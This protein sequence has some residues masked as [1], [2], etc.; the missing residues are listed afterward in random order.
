VQLDRDKLIKRLMATF[1]EELQE[2][3]RIFNAEL[4]ALEQ[5]Q[6]GAST[7]ESIK[8]LFR[9]AH[10]L[11]GAARS[12]QAQ[13]LEGVCHQLE[14]LLAT[15][16]DGERALDAGV[17]KQLFAGVDAWQAA[18]KELRSSAPAARPAP[19]PFSPP[20]T[21]TPVE[22]LNA[23]AGAV[24]PVAAAAS[25]ISSPHSPKTP[26]PAPSLV[27]ATEPLTA[28]PSSDDPHSPSPAS[29]VVRV[30]GGRL[31]ALLSQ[32]GELMV[33]R[34]R[35]DARQAD[36]GLLQDSVAHFRNE[37]QSAR[38]AFIKTPGSRRARAAGTASD[39]AGDG[40]GGMGGMEGLD[41]A[42]DGVP[43]KLV[44]FLKHS[45]EHLAR[46]EKDLERLS[47]GLSED[48]RALDRAATPLEAQIHQARL[49]PFI[50]ACEGLFRS[51]RDLAASQ[52][53][54]IELAIAGGDTELDRSIIDGLR[55][56]LLHLIRNAAWHGIEAPDER[57][58]RHKPRRGTISIGAALH[59][60][61][62]RLSVADDGRGLDLDAVRAQLRKRDLPIPSDEGELARL[63]FQPGFSTASEVTA[64]SG[65]GVGLDV[66][67]AHIEA[68]RG[69]V[70][71]AF[72]PGKGTCF[73]ITLPLTLTTVRVL[74]VDAAGETF[75]FPTTSVRTLVRAGPSS[76]GSVEG[77]DMLLLGEAPIPIVSLGETLGLARAAT[78]LRANDKVPMVIVSVDEQRVALAVDEL[79]GEQEVVLKPLG[80]R[81]R[82]TR[83]FAGATIRSTGHLALVLKPLD[84]ARTALGCGPSAEWSA[85]FSAS[86]P[87]APKRLLLVDDSIT[88]RT[89]EK[90]ILEAAGHE[91]ITAADGA[92]AWQLLQDRGADLVV[93]DVEM[94]I[95]DG[96]TLAETIRS[97]K[98]FRDLPIILLTALHSERDRARGLSAGADAYLLKTT[99]DQKLLLETIRQLL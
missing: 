30:A 81:V 18:G 70:S 5:R 99:F 91:V 59:G 44:R 71:L 49:V 4:I 43:A 46:L 50:E 55:S 6:D 62:V 72:E 48:R 73:S 66:V 56:P 22:R 80:S 26:A 39:P 16:R 89:L 83:H 88:T 45:G 79:L 52:G 84:V 87:T 47:L 7:A 21:A 33:A 64:V 94:P 24:A 78:P 96:F 54:E 93:S 11:K 90:S 82:R 51:V 27:A 85:R 28:R 17:I 19:P 35:F 65:R 98:R 60:D 32:S 61:S 37:W 77:R 53:K 40:V 58:A 34:R 15:I 1:L 41:G 92:A 57:E 42:H 25:A 31:D 67:K 74:F 76:L 12:V 3:V 8:I 23:V 63:I 13:K 20:K 10:S 2:H 36:V 97:S 14:E 69:T 68:M 86:A 9:S 29:T 38:R 75:A 95:M